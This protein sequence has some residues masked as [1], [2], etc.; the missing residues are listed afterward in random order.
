MNK[1][2]RG[3]GERDKMSSPGFRK[4]LAPLSI[5]KESKAR[6]KG[7]RKEILLLSHTRER[8]AEREITCRSSR[9][10]HPHRQNKEKQKKRSRQRKWLLQHR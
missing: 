2:K 5:M 9:G 1:G 3:P 4:K 10:V 6:K 8:T 7:G